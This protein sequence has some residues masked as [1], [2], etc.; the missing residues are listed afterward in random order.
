[1]NEP[2]NHTS[3]D[4]CPSAAELVRRGESL[5]VEFKSDRKCL[6]DHELVCAAVA[7]ANSDGGVVLVGVEDDGCVTG[8]HSRH[9]DFGA[10]ARLVANRTVPQLPVR[11]WTE[12]VDGKS[13]GVL[14]VPRLLNLVATSDGILLRRRLKMDGSPESVPLYPH[15]IVQ[16]Q[17]SLG[18]LDPSAMPIPDVS[19]GDLDPIQRIR[20]RQAIQKYGGDKSLLPLPDEELDRALGF[21]KDVEGVGRPT[22]AGLLFLGTPTLLRDNVPA[23]EVA[24]QVL[25][26][27]DVR[28]NEFYRKPLLETF[29]EVE[30]QFKAW[31][32]E[33]EMQIGLFRMAIPN[34]DRRAFRE[35]FVNA[36]VHRDFSRLGAV[37]V[38]IDDAGLTISNPGGFV[39]GVRLDNLLVAPPRSRNP[40]LADAI[41]RIGLAERTGRGIDRIFEGVLRYGR[42]AP[43]YSD[44]S[45]ETVSLFFANAKPDFDFVKLVSENDD[46]LGTYPTDSIVIL[47]VL[48]ERPRSTLAEL[49]AAVQKKDAAVRSELEALVGHGLVESVGTGRLREYILS[50]EL[51]ARNAGKAAY[52][53]QKG[54]SAIQHEQMILSYIDQHGQITRGEVMELCHLTKDLAY[55]T[56]SR[57][58]SKTIQMLGKSSQAVY[59]RKT[60]Q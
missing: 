23:Y 11:A 47:S 20:I 50:R 38:R 31:V 45:E 5:M 42:P 22:L 34:Y 33:E 3:A 2:S 36:L 41:K 60:V 26:G 24:F 1:M 32:V 15:E 18:R 35:A 28:V 58:C 49:V 17:S 46:K 6:P 56:L 25:R 54:F 9:S 55:K 30:T 44:S 19:E 52:T 12:S 8:L 51:Y 4:T 39:E 7:L 57:M 40:L 27:T 43:D 16:R 37:H 53:R 10:V 14:E 59:V 13:V 48:R 21:V 29:E